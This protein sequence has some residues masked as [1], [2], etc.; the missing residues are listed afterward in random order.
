M[1]KFISNKASILN[2]IPLSVMKQF[3]NCY[4]EKLTNILND[5]LKENRFRNLMKVAKISPV[6]KKFDNTFKDN[7]QPISTSSAFA[8]IFENILYSQLNNYMEKKIL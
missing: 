8:E 2:D 6:L 4:C 3:V 1:K 7:Y 5:C